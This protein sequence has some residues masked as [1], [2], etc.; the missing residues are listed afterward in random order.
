MKGFMS[1][2]Q[3]PQSLKSVMSNLYKD[4]NG[5]YIIDIIKASKTKYKYFE[6]TANSGSKQPRK[7]PAF[8]PKREGKVFG[9]YTCVN[10]C[11]QKGRYVTAVQYQYKIG[12]RY[13]HKFLSKL[14]LPTKN[15]WYGT[16]IISSHTEKNYDDWIDIFKQS[17]DAAVIVMKQNKDKIITATGKELEAKYYEVDESDDDESDSEN[18]SD[19]VVN[20]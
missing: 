18:E 1:F 15:R 13:T 7:K 19:L 3:K 2:I 11:W 5:A 20:D 16:M 4:P 6:N 14:G 10:G 17:M 8:P 9:D 12:G